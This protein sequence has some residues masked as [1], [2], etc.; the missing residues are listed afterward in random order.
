MR[1]LLVLVVMTAFVATVLFLLGLSDGNGAGGNR[2]VDL[3]NG[4][5]RDTSTG[6]IWLK[7]ANCFGT[8]AWQDAMDTAASLAD[9]QC[10]LTDGSVAGDWRLPTGEEWEALFD[11][12]YYGP[13]LSNAAGTGQW[14][15]GDAF[16][17]VQSRFYWSSTTWAATGNT[18]LGVRL[19]NGLQSSYEKDNSFYVWPVRGGK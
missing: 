1:K 18:S 4:T 16:N 7:N 13:A 15:E 9:G 5:V 6:L 11:T 8:K 2:F 17:N 19:S 3:G 12:N 10:G 14:S